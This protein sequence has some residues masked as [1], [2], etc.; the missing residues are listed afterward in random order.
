MNASKAELSSDSSLFIHLL[1]SIAAQAV[2][3]GHALSLFKV[4]PFGIRHMQNIGVLVFF[5]LSGVLITY[6][7]I[8]KKNRSDKYGFK[9]YFMDRFVRIYSGFLPAILLVVILDMI[10]RHL[11]G[12]SIYIY[13]AYSLR[14]FIGN[15]FMFLEEYQASGRCKNSC[16]CD[17]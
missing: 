12:D 15:I 16:V 8:Q 1:R 17:F 11:Y 6:S 4:S 7:T 2:L 13:T 10:I 14:T 5:I 9:S 3:V